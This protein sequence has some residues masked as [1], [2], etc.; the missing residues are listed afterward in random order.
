M[1]TASRDPGP[2]RRGWSVIAAGVALA[3]VRAMEPHLPGAHDYIGVRGITPPWV[4]WAA[5]AATVG[6]G[7]AVLVPPGTRTDPRRVIVRAGWATC[8]L[9]SWSAA[10]I[11]FDGFRAFFRITGI[12][13]GEFAIV[14]W[15]GF[16]TRSIALVA[17][18]LLGYATLRLQRSLVGAC[19]RCGRRPGHSSA[20]G[21]GRFAYAACALAFVYPAVKFYWWLGGRLGRPAVYTEGFPAMETAMLA[22]GVL[23]SLA[24]VRPWGRVF[25]RWVPFLAGRR[26]PRSIPI[27]AGWA[28]SITL[29]LHG[30][31]SVFGLLGSLLSGLPL[32]LDGSANSWIILTV[33]ASWSLFGAALLGATQHYRR[34]TGGR[35]RTCGRPDRP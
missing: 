26:V 3:L 9:L 2:V 5:A 7:I 8:V 32:P 28:L 1:T 19:P 27:G 4:P 15:P 31:T 25:P 6:V 18:V 14:D 10:G 35:C 11:V 12:P 34:Q 22:G 20:A 17:L 13:A 24:L 23:L 16:L 29:V 33:Y 30:A 21:T